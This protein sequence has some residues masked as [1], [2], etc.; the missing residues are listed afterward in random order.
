MAR[1]KELYI[2]S[3]HTKKIFAN[4][5]RIGAGFSGPR[6]KQRKEADVSYDESEDEDHVP[7]LSSDPLPSGEDSSILNELMDFCTSL[8]EQGRKNDDEMFGVDD[9]GGK[10]VVMETAT[11]VKDSSAP[12]TDVTEDEVTMA[13]ALA[14]LKSTKPKVVV[15]E[16][17]KPVVID[18]SKELKKYMEILL[19]NGDEVLIE[20]IPISSRSPTIIDYKIH[21]EGKKNYFKIIRAD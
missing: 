4:M 9:L 13:Q 6:R 3:S 14:A 2:I 16:N 17:V 10:E 11:G 18:D 19:D 21:K 20:A 7:T 12:T 1:H 5:R 15:D 8:Q